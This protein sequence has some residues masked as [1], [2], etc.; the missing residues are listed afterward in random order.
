MTDTASASAQLSGQQR[1]L[2]HCRSQLLANL[3][4][5]ARSIGFIEQKTIAAFVDEAARCH[6]EL[7]GLHDRR[8][9]EQAHGLTASRISLVHEHDLEFTLELTALA[10]RLRDYCRI[11]LSRLHGRYM[12]L[13][14]QRDAAEE[15]TPVG[16]ETVCRA[17]RALADAAGFDPAQ[18]LQFLERCGEPLARTLRTTYRELGATLD[19]AG[20]RPHRAS[21]P[22]PRAEDRAPEPTRADQPSHTADTDARIA[23]LVQ[24]ALSLA[25]RAE[26]REHALIEATA[27]IERLLRADTPNVIGQ[28]LAHWWLP[29]LARLYYNHGGGHPQWRICCELAE[30]LAQSVHPP[31]DS[32]AR[33]R[34]ADAL[35]TLNRKLAQGLAALGLAEE[36]QRAALAPCIA[37]QQA[38]L[39]GTLLPLGQTPTP[40]P[41]TLSAPLGANGLRIFNHNRYAIGAPPPH[42]AAAATRGDWLAIDLP[43]GSTMRGCIGWTGASGHVVVLADPAAPRVLIATRRALAEAAAAGRCRLLHTAS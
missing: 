14:G 24:P 12:M 7:L 25:E 20:L 19:A 15:Q 39:A 11:E 42:P 23:T 13:L 18:R 26:R 3:E 28:F 8:G 30:R 21:A 5:F 29:L 10:R 9:F 2:A 6:D 34:W 27:V 22:A 37:A 32:Q 17:L 1:L 36:A 31:T 40:A 41:A 33:T 38:A 35:P 16:P 4:A 43:D